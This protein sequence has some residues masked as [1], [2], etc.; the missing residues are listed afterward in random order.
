MCVRVCVC[1]CAR[2]RACDL[3]LCICNAYM[4]C[5][6]VC[7]YVCMHISLHRVGFAV[8]R[9]PEWTTSTLESTV[10][11]LAEVSYQTLVPH[12]N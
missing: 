2:V 4:A 3:H 10:S 12:H 7:M 5:T 11:T 9:V 1:V 8:I 6:Y